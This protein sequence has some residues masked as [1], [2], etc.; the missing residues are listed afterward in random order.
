MQKKINKLKETKVFN[1]IGHG[2]ETYHKAMNYI[3]EIIKNYH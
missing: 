1:N 2:I 3:G